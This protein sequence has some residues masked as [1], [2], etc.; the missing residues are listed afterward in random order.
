[1]D[2]PTYNPASV[3]VPLTRKAKA[4]MAARREASQ[5]LRESYRQLGLKAPAPPEL[6]LT[7]F[8]DD[9]SCGT[10]TYSVENNAMREVAAEEIITQLIAETSEAEV[11]EYYNLKEDD[12]LPGVEIDGRDSYCGQDIAYDEEAN[13]DVSE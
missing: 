11:R 6:G 4:S 5:L 13:Y 3:A 9:G 2:V 8:V 7:C 10:A 1:L 12:P